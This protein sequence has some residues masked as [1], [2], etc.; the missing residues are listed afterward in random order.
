GQIPRIEGA[1]VAMDP[2]TGAILALNGGIKGAESGFNRATQ[3]IR[4]PGSAFKPFIYAAALS[5]GY[6]LAT[7]IDDAPIAINDTGDPNNLWRPQ[8]DNKQFYGEMRMRL[9]L[10]KS[11]NVM[12]VRLLQMVGLQY[13]LDYL[14]RF[15][16]DPETLPHGLSLALG[17]ASVT[18]LQM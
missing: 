6:T 5:H 18:P 14:T 7:I 8:N 2:D 13:T 15:G 10:V 11:I 9:G 1:I 4:Q 17:T 3:S 16:F 12:T